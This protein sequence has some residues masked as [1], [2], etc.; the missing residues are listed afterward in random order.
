MSK[1]NK[2]LLEVIRAALDCGSH[3]HAPTIIENDEFFKIGEKAIVIC[4]QCV[5]RMRNAL[6]L[7]QDESVPTA[8]QWSN[9]KV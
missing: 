7:T 5:D 2:Q 6:G 4:D 8:F 1:T 9:R 3:F